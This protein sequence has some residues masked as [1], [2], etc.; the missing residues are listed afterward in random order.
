[1]IIT[2][3]VF[4]Q[5]KTAGFRRFSL[6]SPD[7]AVGEFSLICTVSNFKNI[8]ERIKDSKNAFSKREIASVMAQI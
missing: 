3:P 7:K 1:M 5:I 2:E 6:M 4:G 8:V